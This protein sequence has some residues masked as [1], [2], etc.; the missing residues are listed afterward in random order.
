MT[1]ALELTQTN[2]LFKPIFL[3]S[4]KDLSTFF[5][6]N[7]SMESFLKTEAYYYHIQRKAST[8]LIYY[9]ETL[10]GYFTLQRTRLQLDLTEDDGVLD[11]HLY[12]V[13][14]GTANGL[15]YMLMDLYDPLLLKEFFDE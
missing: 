13:N 14:P 8:T 5:C 6:E 1:K 3:E 9:K 12:E 15:V 7:S 4:Y 11:Q 2:L 10:A